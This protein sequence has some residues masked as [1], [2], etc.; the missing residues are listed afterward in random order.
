MAALTSITTADKRRIDAEVLPLTN[1][2]HM[3]AHR[4]SL[5]R[6]DTGRRSYLARRVDAE[7]VKERAMELSRW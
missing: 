6:I 7:W 2:I 5:Y 1:V 4:L 3:Q